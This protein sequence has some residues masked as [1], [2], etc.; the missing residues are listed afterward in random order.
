MNGME[1]MVDPDT[2]DA[3]DY[4]YTCGRIVGTLNHG[5]APQWVANVEDFGLM[6]ATHRTRVGAVVA[7]KKQVEE[8]LQAATKEG[9]LVLEPEQHVK[10][11]R[12]RGPIWCWSE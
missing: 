3:W 1:C 6:N 9:R 11:R 8:A 4:H 12:A 5:E 7:L 10:L 2:V